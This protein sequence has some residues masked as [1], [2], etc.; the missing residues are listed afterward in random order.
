MSHK[1]NAQRAAQ[2]REIFDA[3]LG[4]EDDSLDEIMEQIAQQYEHEQPVY[5]ERASNEQVRVN[6]Y[7]NLQ[8][9]G[10]NLIIA[11]KKVAIHQQLT[12]EK[13][14][15]ATQIYGNQTIHLSNRLDRARRM[16][17]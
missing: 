16:D 6:T 7:S 11:T 5:Q 3:F 4:Q 1:Q 14:G 12:G 2:K 13:H 10:L 8:S 17:C 9:V 15:K